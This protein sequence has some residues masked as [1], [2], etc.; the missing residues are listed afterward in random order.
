MQ[1]PTVI[2]IAHR[3]NTIFKADQIIVLGGRRVIETGTLALMTL[4]SFE[5]VAPLPLAAQMW[6]SSREAARRLFDVVDAGPAVK[7]NS[8]ES[9][10]TNYELQISNLTFSYPSQNIPALRDITITVCL[11]KMGFIAA[12]GIYRIKFSSSNRL[13]RHILCLTNLKVSS[14]KC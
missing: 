1:G 10:I 11:H 5:A 14:E 4:A 12:Y 9:S 6:T 8:S 7:D 3:L 13:F 2:T